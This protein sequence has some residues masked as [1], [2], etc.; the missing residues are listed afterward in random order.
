MQ[1]YV[2]AH[3]TPTS[4]YCTNR[5]S[6][7]LISKSAI[8]LLR[9]ERSMTAGAHMRGVPSRQSRHLDATVGKIEVVGRKP[10]RVALAPNGADHP[11]DILRAALRAQGCRPSLRV[12]VII[13]G[14]AGLADL[15]RAAMREAVRRILDWFHFSMR[16]SPIEQMLV[17]LSSRDRRDIRPLQAAQAS[18]ERGRHLLWHGRRAQAGQELVRFA[19]HSKNFARSGAEPKQ[20]VTRDFLRTARGCPVMCKTT[21]LALSATIIGIT[22]IDQYRRHALRDASAK[23]HHVQIGSAGRMLESLQRIGD[24]LR[25]DHAGDENEIG[26]MIARRPSWQVLWRMYHVLRHLHDHRAGA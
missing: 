24:A 9:L 22:A 3:A 4:E 10:R 7:D 21:A 26:T 13:N 12:I 23:V 18:I 16:M 15:V 25:V 17:R 11:I 19:H 6:V 2:P 20:V 5:P 1:S 8:A 14:E